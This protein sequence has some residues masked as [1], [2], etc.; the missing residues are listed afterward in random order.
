MSKN[1]CDGSTLSEKLI[2]IGSTFRWSVLLS[3]E[4]AFCISIIQLSLD[5][6]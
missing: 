3:F 6:N 1:S 5:R 2:P 4:A